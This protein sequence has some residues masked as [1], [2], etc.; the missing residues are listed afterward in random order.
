MDKFIEAFA[1]VTIMIALAIVLL[2]LSTFLVTLPIDEGGEV[3]RLATAG[4]LRGAA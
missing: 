2:S 4:I 1:V 3:S